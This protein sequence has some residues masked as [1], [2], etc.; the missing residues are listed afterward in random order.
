[1]K[2]IPDPGYTLSK[3]DGLTLVEVLISMGI[4]AVGFLAIGALVIGTT[5]N[6]TTGNTLTEATMLARAKI[7]SLKALSLSQLEVA[8]PQNKAPEI[9]RQLYAR[10]CE[11]GSLGG[12]TTIKK[13]K[14]TVSWEKFGKLRRV[15]LETNTRGRGT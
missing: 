5:K 3:R 8:C 10:Q 9:I 4:F 13:I 12:S 7:E 1:M 2:I 14:V 6:N 15:V 11:V